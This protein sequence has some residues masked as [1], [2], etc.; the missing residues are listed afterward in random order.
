MLDENEIPSILRKFIVI[1]NFMIKRNKKLDIHYDFEFEFMKETDFLQIPKAIILRK[2]LIQK[3]FKIA[4]NE[5]LDET[6]I[7]DKLNQIYFEKFSL[8]EEK[9]KFKKIESSSINKM[10]K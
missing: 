2:F 4:Q 5:L 8:N 10:K 1:K 7:K 6:L 3:N 9:N